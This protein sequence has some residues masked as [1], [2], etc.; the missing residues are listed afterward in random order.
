M[1]T[2]HRT[3]RDPAFEQVCDA[4]GH[5]V[6]LPAARPGEDEQRAFRHLLTTPDPD[7]LDLLTEKTVADDE[8]LQNVIK[9]LLKRT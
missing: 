5:H 9:R 7:I 8:L 4:V 3:G 2:R 6:G 1:L